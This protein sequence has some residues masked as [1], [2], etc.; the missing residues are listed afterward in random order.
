MKNVLITCNSK[1]IWLNTCGEKGVGV[2]CIHIVEVLV[3]NITSLTM[4]VG[5]VYHFY[6]SKKQ[7]TKPKVDFTLTWLNRTHLTNNIFIYIDMS[8]IHQ[9]ILSFYNVSFKIT[10][11]ILVFKKVDIYTTSTTVSRCMMIS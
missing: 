3:R 1:L 6:D 9:N 4:F 2:T 8:F 5:A 11:K 10:P 7:K